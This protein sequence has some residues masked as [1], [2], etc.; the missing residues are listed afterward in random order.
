MDPDDVINMDQMPIPHPYHASWTLEKGTKTIH[1]LPS[2]ADTK[3]AT[4]TAY[5][6]GSGKLLTLILIF[7]GQTEGKIAREEL[8]TY[9]CGCFYAYQPNAWMDK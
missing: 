1:V 3:H 2:T 7:K 6:P 8:Q 9:T 4:L 5:V